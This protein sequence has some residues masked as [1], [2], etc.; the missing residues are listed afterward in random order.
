MTSANCRARFQW[1]FFGAVVMV[2]AISVSGCGGNKRSSEAVPDSNSG[3]RPVDESVTGSVTGA[4]KFEGTP[5]KARTINMASVPSCN[6]Q[7]TSPATTED[8]VLGDQGTLQNVVVYLKGDFS[9]YSFPKAATPVNVDQK[10]CLY[11]PHVA[12]LMT[13]ET[14]QITNSDLATHNVNAMAKSN[15]PW[16]ESEPPG[17][18]TI[19]QQFTR[20][21]VAIRVKCNIHAWMKL[22]VAVLRHPYFQVTGKDGSFALKNVPP[23]K[24]TLIAWHEVYGT[25]EQEITINPKQEQSVTLTFTGRDGQ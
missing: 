1:L 19:N 10:G 12:A 5:P 9:Q 25:R 21:E 22:Y 7:R 8:V 13:G 3:G 15:R 11:T 20:E 18:A 14:L 24:Y 2:L 17:A 16:N 4:V 6:S 23:G